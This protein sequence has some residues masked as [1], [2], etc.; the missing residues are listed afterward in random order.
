MTVGTALSRVEP[1]KF[2]IKITEKKNHKV[3]SEDNELITELS[4]QASSFSPV[5]AMP[6]QRF[7]DLPECGDLFSCFIPSPLNACFYIRLS[8][9]QVLKTTSS[10]TKQPESIH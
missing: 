8:H 3:C 5:V 10:M 9:Q 7:C 4:L 6:A 1:F 2:S